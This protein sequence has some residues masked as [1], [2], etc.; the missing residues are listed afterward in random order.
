MK[1]KIAARIQ[2]ERLGYRSFII[3]EPL[4]GS[5]EDAAEIILSTIRNYKVAKQNSE[6]PICLI[7]GG[8]TTVKVIGGGR[9]GRNQDL[10]LRLSRKIAGL[11]G[12]L[13]ITLATDGEDGPTDA[14]GAV[15]DSESFYEGN[16]KGLDIKSFIVDNNAYEYFDQLG[17]LIRIGATGT[18][19][20]DL[21]FVLLDR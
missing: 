20:N 14:A 9:G 17:G 5:T 4:T 6:L 10:A 13:C 18:N 21:M 2:A 19:V 1:A 16:R 3:I 15:V 12:V 11:P 7:F 8:E